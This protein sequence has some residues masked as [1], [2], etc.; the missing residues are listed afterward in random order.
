MAPIGSSFYLCRC[1]ALTRILVA[2]ST[3]ARKDALVKF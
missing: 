1:F 2:V 3:K